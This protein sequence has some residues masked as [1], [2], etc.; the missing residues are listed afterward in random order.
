MKNIKS[1]AEFPVTIYSNLEKYSDTITKARVRIFYKGINRNGS[2]ISDEFAEKLISTISYAPIK[3]IYDGNDYTD[4]GRREFG[5][6]Y[7][8][9]PDNPNFSWENFLDEDGIER[10]YACVDVLLYTAL[11]EEAEKIIGKSQSMEIYDKTIEG[12]WQFINGKQVFVF[13]DGS[14]LGLQVLGE[15]VEPCFEGA[16]FF[17]KEDTLDNII[18]KI[19]QYNYKLQEK[20]NQEVKMHDL[21]SIF[22]IS[23]N[24]KHDILW[25]LLNPNDD[26]EHNWEVNYIIYDIYDQYAVAKKCGEYSFVRVYY[27]KNDETDSLTIDNIVP[28]FIVDV[29]EDE[30]KSLELIQSLNN[31][32]YEK[33]DEVFSS[34]KQENENFESKINEMNDSISTLTTERDN[35]VAQYTEANELL[36]EAQQSLNEA[37]NNIENLQNTNNELYSF[38]EGIELSQKQEIISSYS[39]ILNK[40]VLDKYFENISNFG[41]EELDKELAYEAK[42]N[43]PTIFN[44][45]SSSTP[46]IPKDHVVTG[47]EAILNKYK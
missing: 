42:K 2:Y 28:C 11:Y 29:T 1:V 26:E 8:I 18:K 4:H 6:I 14:F 19:E 37:K 38:K 13:T 16:A 47:V 7:G 43:N 17:T 41:I 36:V 9:V 45:V 25:S 40:E 12:D 20:H 39:E 44:K 34:L 30:K 24:Q 23:D 22:K 27:T 32:T 10:E 21:K 3:G 35:A 46:M 15:N 5:R 31:G 33:I